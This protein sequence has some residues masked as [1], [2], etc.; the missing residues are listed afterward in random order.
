MQV[1]NEK[2]W[3]G[4][5]EFEDNKVMLWLSLIHISEPTRP[6]YK[7]QG[8]VETEHKRLRIV[9]GSLKNMKQ[10]ERHREK[11]ERPMCRFIHEPPF[12]NSRPLH[13]ETN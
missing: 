10:I 3:D 7:E 12:D 6:L 11:T 2:N 8:M 4:H 5:L 13:W 1:K 9:L